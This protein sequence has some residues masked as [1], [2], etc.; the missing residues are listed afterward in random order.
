MRKKFQKINFK[1]RE[2]KNSDREWVRNFISKEWGSE[3]IISR[4]KIHYPHK[5]PGFIAFNGKKYLGLITYNI[6]KDDCEIVSINTI[7]KRKGI[8]RALVE[9]VKRTAKNL[10]CKRLWL[11][12]TNDNIDGLIFWQK[13]GFSLKKVYPNAISFSRKLKPEIPEI[14]NYGIPVRDEIELEFNLNSKIK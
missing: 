4:G 5:L 7:L 12:T 6:E 1:I 11:V 14:G 2:I 3:K 13:V 8:G 9:K 10:G